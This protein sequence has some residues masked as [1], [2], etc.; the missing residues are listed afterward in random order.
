MLLE[1]D[2][3]C[4]LLQSNHHSIIVNVTRLIQ[5]CHLTAHPTATYSHLT[6]TLE[7]T[8]MS[9]YSIPRAHFKAHLT[10]HPTATLQ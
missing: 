4:D 8:L 7:L 3:C 1:R 2:V 6:A 5:G 10:A 9:P